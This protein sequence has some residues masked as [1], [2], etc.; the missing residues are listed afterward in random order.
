M[1]S[2]TDKPADL[3][4]GPTELTFE[5]AD[6]AEDLHQGTQDFLETKAL[7]TT[8]TFEK[9]YM[10]PVQSSTEVTDDVTENTENHIH[11]LTNTVEPVH[12]VV[13]FAI[14][15]PHEITE[16][17]VELSEAKSC[18]ISDSVKGENGAPVFPA[19]QTGED[20]HM[21]RVEN[22]SPPATPSDHKF[23]SSADFD[24]TAKDSPSE[25]AR[26]TR[27]R[28]RPTDSEVKQDTINQHFDPPYI[29]ATNEEKNNWK[30]FCEIES[31]PVC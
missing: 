1:D 8:D 13:E 18:C 24:K 28:K 20:N 31:D 25:M 4:D 30:G 29:R 12:D 22:S 26:I 5:A 14:E 23:P 10:E 7:E 2:A 3:G 6:P 27:K 11:D 21:T 16:T 19:S 15:P 9:Q 17:T